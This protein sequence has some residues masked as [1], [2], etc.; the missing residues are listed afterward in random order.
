MAVEPIRKIR[1]VAERI[2]LL[3]RNVARM[4]SSVL[5]HLAKAA[6]DVSPVDT[7]TWITSFAVYEGDNLSSI[8]AL[9]SSLGK[10]GEQDRSAFEGVGRAKLSAMI[11]MLDHST[12]S[13][14]FGNESEHRHDVEVRWKYQVFS[15]TAK[16]FEDAAAKALLEH[17]DMKQQGQA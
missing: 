2:A 7:G 9:Y 15:E 5:N 13:Y 3:E 10:P 4:N 1:P 17:S 12:G 11:D 6:V 14:I 16:T 8:P